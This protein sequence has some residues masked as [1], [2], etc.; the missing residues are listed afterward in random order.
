MT[1]AH[2]DSQPSA[3]RT[4]ATRGQVAT[5]KIPG[6]AIELRTRTLT[7]AEG[8]KR[9]KLGILEMGASVAE[10]TMSFDALPA[11]RAAV[12]AAVREALQHRQLSQHDGAAP[13]EI[14]DTHQE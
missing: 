2:V 9:L 6:T 14:N 11:F 1:A 4:R 8:T 3:P 5:F 13:D 12:G 7:D 10:L